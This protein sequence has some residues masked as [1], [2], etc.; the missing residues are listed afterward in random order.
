MATYEFDVAGKKKFMS[1][2]VRHWMTNHEAGIGERPG[3]GGNTVGNIFYGSKGYMAIDGY[4]TYKVFLG[5]KAE[6]GPSKK[7]GGS[8]HANFLEAVRAGKPE[9]LNGHIEEGAISCTLMHLANISYRVGRSLKVDPATG[10][11]LGDAEAS[12]L[13]RR[14]YRK[15]F[16]VPDKV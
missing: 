11:I 10:D 1:F 8:H 4:D 7:A 9:M 2:E 12:A 15:P 5:R 6:P 16:V 14:T 3:G 13:M